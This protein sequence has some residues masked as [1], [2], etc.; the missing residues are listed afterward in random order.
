MQMRKYQK[1]AATAFTLL[2]VGMVVAAISTNYFVEVYES[3]FVTSLKKKFTSFNEKAKQDRL[4]LQT[5]KTL[6]QPGETLWFTAFVRDEQTLKPSENSDIL[7]VEFITPKGTT[8]KHYK[9]VAKNGAAQG[10]FDLS[11]M[12]GGI[13]K[14]KAY[15]QWQKNEDS[16]QLFEK[17]ITIQSVVMPRLK[18]KMEFEKRVYGKGDEVVAKLELNT[19]ANQPLANTKVKF[20]GM[21]A[22][23]EISVS[24]VTTDAQGKTQIKFTLPK[25]LNTVDGVVNAMIDFEGSTESVSRSVPIVLN[26]IKVEFFPE[27]GDMV[28]NLESK[29]AFKA[30]NE[31][32]K[33]ADIQG[34]VVN[35]KGEFVT[36]LSSYHFGM[37]AFKLNPKAGEKYKLRITKPEGILDEFELPQALQI[38]YTLGVDK[39]SG[40]NLQ[41]N[42]NS[43]QNEELSVIAQTRSKIYYAKSFKAAKGSN[44]LAI[45][46]RDFPIGISQI[47]LFDSKGIARCERLA[48]VN[49]NKQLK[50][51][52]TSDKQQYQPREKVSM[53]INVTD[54][55]GL[56]MPGTFA[57]SVVDDNLLSFADDKQGNILSKMLL[58]PDLKEKVEEANFY[59]N[60]KEEKA[61]QA[62]DY[63]MMTSGWRH[64]TW[65]QIQ[66]ED[67]PLA[68]FEAEKAILAGTVLDAYTGQ[69]VPGALLKFKNTNKTAWT[70][71]NGKFVLSRFDITKTN[72]LEIDANGFETQL[73]TVSAYG[74]EN[75]FYLYDGRYKQLQERM[76]MAD[77][78][79]MVPAMAGAANNGVE[80]E[81]AKEELKKA[82]GRNED[83]REIK[84]VVAQNKGV[85]D[86]EPLPAP[87]D[88]IE[89][90]NEQ[91]V[92]LDET[93]ATVAS[94]IDDKRFPAMLDKNAGEGNQV[95]YYRAKEFPKRKYS[96]TDTTRNDFGT[97]V[98]WNGNVETDRWG[99]AK[100]EFTT[101]DLISSFK[102]TIEG[103]G[104]DGSI[105][106]TEYNYST[107]LPFSMDVKLPVEA[108]AGDKMMI[109]VFLK[110]TTN[111]EINGRMV[112]ISPKQFLVDM[113][114]KE[115]VIPAKE[116]KV[117]YLQATASNE[118]GKGRLEIKFESARYNDAFN[119]EV[120]VV[121]KGF[122]ASISMSGQDLDKQFII[123]PANVVP[124]SLKVT[125]NAYPNVMSDLMS[126][127]DA[128]LQEPSGC[129]E[130]TSSSNYPNIMA[131][132]YLQNTKT[133]DPKTEA[134][135]K[136][137]LDNGYKKLVA[138]ETKEN[139]YEWFGA[140]PAHEALT[141]YGLM[142]FVDM[143]KVY[144]QVDDKM[145]ERTVALLLEK[146]DGNGG[147]KKNPR[148]LDSFGAADADITNCY[149]VYAMSEAGKG[150]LVE[151]EIN[152]A[153]KEA[154]KSNDPYM[155]A[156]MANT[157]FNVNDAQRGEELLNILMN[158]RQE[159]GFWTG[160]KH[161]ITR[162]TGEALKIET[163]SLVILAMMKAKETDVSNLTG[164]V[165]YL[166]S[167]RSGYGMFGSTQS[168]ILAL[169]A[170]SKYAEFSKKTDE[171]GT[172][173]VLVNG[174]VV[175]TKDFAKGE[176][177]NVQITG[178]EQYV[179]AGK[180][181]IA[182]RFKGCKNALPYTVNVSYSTTLPESSRQC[183]V[184][185]ETKLSAKQVKVGETLR[186]SATLKNKTNEGQP[187]TM[188]IIGLPAGF[189]AQPWQLKEM[190]EKGVVDFYE[191][192]GNNVACYYRDLAPGEQKQ[193]NFDLKAEV[194]GEYNAPASSAY[195]YYTNE[196]K[197]WV[198]LEK[199][200]VN[201]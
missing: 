163:T 27:G 179:T 172:I 145:I 143:K 190:Q 22:G 91:P 169:K 39:N 62:L 43:W 40:T 64:Y 139:G 31:F 150:N 19:N 18:M 48:F 196:H 61:G 103:F 97:T 73:Q 152:A 154:K 87:P 133:A 58:E 46:T 12:P 20:V 65:K 71:K 126:G 84:N 112:V 192:I 51:S 153:F 30:T 118:I 160:K 175:A 44:L 50:I 149:I 52:I 16:L 26:K 25:D 117:I 105:G 111:Q 94:K 144:P 83:L 167:T 86:L 34:I 69:A 115:V 189:T 72:E 162:S 164:A 60:T 3:E 156:L 1:L 198:G 127:I 168:T 56:P 79:M 128:I 54:Q 182:V 41:L 28:N 178:L 174:A 93:G 159:A 124:G 14:V 122:P 77:D 135:A 102:T 90:P 197:D 130:Q 7:H 101:N 157:M 88:V 57:L 100:V 146:R 106:R 104:D 33:P 32:D 121:A 92:T 35:S 129:F 89:N 123:N 201:P 151:K 125:F 131:L 15:T 136:Q 38:G 107:E 180:Q 45:N 142:E 138:F 181:Q 13:Y 120:S 108:V 10:D 141:A 183:A 8:A 63:L 76:F 134:K 80:M 147:F 59:F 161:S 6:Y 17:E 66:N 185:L 170:L 70:D 24:S 29:V 158:S 114:S 82:K 23:K 166:V 95:I 186:L 195:L 85:K 99:R 194:A 140:A 11:G 36:D 68:R 187:M 109:P 177:N 193:I 42:V 188:A 4:Y 9:L 74:K 2:S 116:S 98:Y 200:F 148:A 21:L 113:K 49:N 165:K 191:I 155:L 55:N 171:A 75:Y 199:V 132:S 110:N 81:V 37:G 184:S 67:L 176:R 78:V 53:T 137:L 119:R 173:E 5:D 96:A 47:T